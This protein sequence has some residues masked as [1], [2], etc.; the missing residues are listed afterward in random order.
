MESAL[1]NEEE[2]PSSFVPSVRAL[3]EIVSNAVVN[4]V[5]LSKLKTLGKPFTGKWTHFS[6]SLPYG[7]NFLKPFCLW[8]KKSTI[9]SE[10]ERIAA[11]L[12]YLQQRMID[13]PP[14]LQW[15]K[16]DRRN[17][18]SWYVYPEGSNH[19]QWELTLGYRKVTGITLQPSMW[20]EDN[21]YQGKAV[22]LIL[23]G[24]VDI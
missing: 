18:F 10:M 21:A 20:Y 2:V 15:D 16:D 19:S 5:F 22:F 17:P 23:E 6:V 14:I 7:G 8:Q 12:P 11:I 1:W 13:A 9:M 24:N 3:R 4:G